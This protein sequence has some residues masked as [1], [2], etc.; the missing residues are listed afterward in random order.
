VPTRRRL[1]RGK[2]AGVRRRA[3]ADRPAGWPICHSAPPR[4]AGGGEAPV[5]TGI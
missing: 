2:S 5:G 3:S 4:C 1:T